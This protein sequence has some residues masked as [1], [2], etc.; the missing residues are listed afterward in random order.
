[1]KTFLLIAVILLT[2]VSAAFAQENTVEKQ[3]AEVK[4]LE[5]M[6]GQ[7]K[8]SGWI[9]QGPNRE[10]FTGTEMV[11]RKLDG[12]AILIEGKFTNPE[13]KVIHETLAVLSFDP[14]D[15]KY[16]FR[17]YLASGMGGEFDFQVV[18]GGYK[19]GFQVQGGTIRYTIKTDN[20]A[21]FEIGEF[22]RDG[23]TW[24]KFFEMNLNKVK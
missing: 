4:K 16:R 17:T 10:N 11:Q 23:Q 24:M 9:Q 6:V 19:W 18:E 7:W 2:T 12:L 3:R 14:K 13:G 8:G 21:W 20:D 5:S 15:S 22:S 1:M